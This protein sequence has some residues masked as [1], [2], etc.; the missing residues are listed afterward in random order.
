MVGA[1]I[2]TGRSGRGEH[3]RLLLVVAGGLLFAVAE[4]GRHMAQQQA[5]RNFEE[6]ASNVQRSI[7]LAGLSDSL[8]LRFNQYHQHSQPIPGES[9]RARSGMRPTFLMGGPSHRLQ[10]RELL[11]HNP[12]LDYTSRSEIFRPR[13]AVEAAASQNE[14]YKPPAP[15]M[16]G[17]TRSPEEDDFLQCAACEQE[18]GGDPIHERGDEVWAGRCGHVSFP[19][20][21][22]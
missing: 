6:S 3:R 7:L 12:D 16:E 18:L 15:A 9:T 22:T 5:H 8:Q 17:F 13:D 21:A 4:S 11:F 2:S 20:F 14:E 10:G 19:F 1:G